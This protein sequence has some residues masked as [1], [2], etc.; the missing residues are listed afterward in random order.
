MNFTEIVRTCEISTFSTFVEHLGSFDQ[1]QRTLTTFGQLLVEKIVN[2]VNILS[3]ERCK[4]SM[5]EFQKAILAR[6]QT[7]HFLCRE[8]AHLFVE[9]LMRMRL[10]SFRG[11]HRFSSF[12]EILSFESVL[13]SI[14]LNE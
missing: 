9:M 3:L 8:Y 12:A 1:T 6:P 10:S 14:A 4:N 11:F 2:L 7:V 5:G 13:F